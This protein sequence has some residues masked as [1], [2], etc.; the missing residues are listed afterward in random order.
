MEERKLVGK[1][2][3]VGVERRE[4]IWVSECNLNALYMSQGSVFFKKR[5]NKNTA[6]SRKYL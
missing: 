5:N 3:V 4:G 2:K 6:K 1:K